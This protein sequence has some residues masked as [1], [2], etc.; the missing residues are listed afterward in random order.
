[1]SD[2]ELNKLKE[3][4]RMLH[5]TM[6]WLTTEVRRKDYN[7][8]SAARCHRAVRE[9]AEYLMDK[10]KGVRS[11]VPHIISAHNLMRQVEREVW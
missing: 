11:V 5:E 4:V 1:M 8:A 9:N 2:K 6:S 10:Y 7:A 3:E